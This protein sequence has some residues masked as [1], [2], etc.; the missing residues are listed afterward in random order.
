[1][2]WQGKSI[3]PPVG[4]L[5]KAR[6][7]VKPLDRIFPIPLA[8]STELPEEVKGGAKGSGELVPGC[9]FIWPFS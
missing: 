2:D 4:H 1:M 8:V 3:G 9:S 6:E 7:T 5:N